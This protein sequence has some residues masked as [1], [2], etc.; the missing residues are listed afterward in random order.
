MKSLEDIIEEEI[1]D[2]PYCPRRG[3]G[4]VLCDAENEGYGCTREKGH[5]GYHRACGTM[6]HPLSD[7]DATWYNEEE[8]KDK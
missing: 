5:R 6:Q 1:E 8:G 2:C 4:K 7:K 3:S